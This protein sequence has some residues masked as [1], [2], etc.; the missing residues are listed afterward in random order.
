MN[1]R[2][3][4]AVALALGAVG[5][6]DPLLACGEKFLMRTRGTRFQRAAPARSSAAILVYAD[7]ASSLPKA[8]ANVPVDATLRKAGYRPS[9]VTSASEFNTALGRGGWDLVLVDVAESG[10]VLKHAQGSAGPVVLPVVFN[11]SSAELAAAKKQ[12]QRILKAPTK[13]QRFLDA[14]DDALASKPA[15]TSR[16]EDGPRR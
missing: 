1:S 13:S 2:L 8:L 5:L 16:A 11:A 3:I 14:I 6:S 15:T 10:E 12:H 4:A 7:P 9:T